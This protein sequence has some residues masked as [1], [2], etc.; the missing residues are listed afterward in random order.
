MKTIITTAEKCRPLS[1]LA[2]LVAALLTLAPGIAAQDGGWAVKAS[3]PVPADTR[4]ELLAQFLKD[5]RDVLECLA[6]EGP[7]AKEEYLSNVSVEA[8]DLN[9][10]GRPEYFVEPSGG[11]DCGAHA[12]SRLRPPLCLPCGDDWLLATDYCFNQSSLRICLLRA[13]RVLGG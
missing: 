5:H 1:A 2:C 3:E 9:R 10:D 4:R 13:L 7:R 6:G 8:V 12:G 11:C